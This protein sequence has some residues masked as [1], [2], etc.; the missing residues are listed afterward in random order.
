[1]NAPTGPAALR[2]QARRYRMAAGMLEPG[3][4][5]ATVEREAAELERRASAWAAADAARTVH[6]SAAIEAHARGDRDAWRAEWA[7]A[8]EAHALREAAREARLPDDYAPAAPAA[9][10]PVRFGARWRA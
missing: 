8:L 5:R 2:S 6:S 1:M 3:D 7:A 9:P 4:L 10:A